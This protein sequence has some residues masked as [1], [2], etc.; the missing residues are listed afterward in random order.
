[1]ENIHWLSFQKQFQYA[2]TE[3]QSHIILCHYLLLKHSENNRNLKCNK[4][5]KQKKMTS[6]TN[7]LRIAKE[8]QI[9]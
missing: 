9:F 4:N 2:D 8:S 5:E 3:R 1:M 7:H 6:V